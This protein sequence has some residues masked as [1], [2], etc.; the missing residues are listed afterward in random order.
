ML[1]HC[2]LECKLIQPLWKMVWRFL[3][4]LGIK[5]P[6]DP[7]ISLLGIYPEETKTE[8]DSCIPLFIAA[9]FTIARTWKQPSCPWTDEWIKKVWYIYAMEYSVQFSRSLMSN[10]LRPH[11]LHHARPPCLSPT[12]G[13][14]PN[15]CPLSRCPSFFL[16]FFFTDL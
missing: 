5:P 6:Y 10:S 7:A 9:L 14:Y 16:E 13:V 4:K 11:E 1:L 8:R 2:C 12:P 15:S 3:K